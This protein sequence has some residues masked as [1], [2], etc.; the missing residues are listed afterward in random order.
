MSE[1]RT[2]TLG[3]GSGP[4]RWLVHGGMGFGPEAYAH[5]WLEGRADC[6]SVSTCTRVVT[7]GSRAKDRVAKQCKQLRSSKAV[8]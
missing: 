6:R 5:A 8:V 3:Y 7:I 1:R 4:A 2:L